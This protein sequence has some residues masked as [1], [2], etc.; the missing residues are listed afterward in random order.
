MKT[1]PSGLR[2]HSLVGGTLANDVLHRLREDIISCL[3]KPGERLRFEPLREIYGVSFSTL[4]EALSR[5][6]S[7]KLV[8]AEGQRGFVVAPISVADLLD[9]TNARVLLERECVRLSM[10]QGGPEWKGLILAAYHR[11]DRVDATLGD[12]H[13]VTSDWD[14][15]HFD[16]HE[17]LVGAA[18]SPIL[19]EMRHA[20]FEKARRY[21]RLSAL[22]R[23]SPGV[24]RAE[25]RSLM[26]AVLSEDVAAAQDMV[27]RHIR[28]VAQNVI[29]N[30]LELIA[31]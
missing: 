23:K 3:L 2:S 29:D 16:F 10:L 1:E 17:M 11:L 28:E 25:H 19:N 13:R 27:E 20:L 22:V 4:R 26:E 31:A 14:R 21:R 9:L 18:G 12:A 6:A 7:E 15:V 8:I 24:K 5:L 30:G